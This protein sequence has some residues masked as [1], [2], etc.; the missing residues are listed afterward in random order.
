MKTMEKGRAI[1]RW[2]EEGRSFFFAGV[3]FT[4]IYP[5]VNFYPLFRAI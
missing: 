4:L 1:K 3:N 5:R 2:K